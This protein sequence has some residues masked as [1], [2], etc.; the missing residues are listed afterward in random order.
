ML[1]MMAYAVKNL[2][3]HKFTAKIGD[4]N[5]ASLSLF[6]KLVQLITLTLNKQRKKERLN[7]LVCVCRVS[8]T[9]LTVKS[10]KR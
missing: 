2:E 8:R 5:T 9:L 4:S 3:I 10:S 6:R 7:T 1:L